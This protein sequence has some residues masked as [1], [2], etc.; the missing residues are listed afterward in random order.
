MK[1]VFNSSVAPMT[2]VLV[3]GISA[4]VVFSLQPRRAHQS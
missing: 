2:I 3:T 4:A 1:D